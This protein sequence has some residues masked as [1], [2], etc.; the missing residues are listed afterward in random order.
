MTGTRFIQN[1]CNHLQKY[2]ISLIQKPTFKIFI[3]LLHAPPPQNGL[4]ILT[5]HPCHT[6]R[7]G[8]AE[9]LRER[10]RDLYMQRTYFIDYIVYIPE[11]V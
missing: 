7:E 5:P 4:K 6:H 10:E 2:I 9:G 3:T 11:V 1:V 8:E